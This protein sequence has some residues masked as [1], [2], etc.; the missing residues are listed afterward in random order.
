MVAPKPQPTPEPTS[1]T[2]SEPGPKPSARPAPPRTPPGLV[3]TGERA[4]LVRKPHMAFV[5]LRTPRSIVFA[6]LLAAAGF[7]TRSASWAQPF[8]GWTLWSGLALLAALLLANT[9]RRE[10]RWYAMTERRLIRVGGVFRR[11]RVELPLSRVR[12][13][14]VD[15]PFVQRLFG[16]GNV[17]AA[18][19][20][21][22]GVEMVWTYVSRPTLT[23]DRIR[24]RADTGPPA[25]PAGPGVEL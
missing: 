3:P 10:V 19:A 5:F 7:L 4:L 17:L 20:A 12:M 15:E 23:A 21:T 11:V 14:A 18:S 9:I 8:S 25:E 1:G 13:I 16:V 24:A 6:M 2:G 22:G